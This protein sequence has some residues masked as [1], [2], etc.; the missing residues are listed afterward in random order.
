MVATNPDMYL[1]PSFW[2]LAAI[3][4]GKRKTWLALL[5]N[6]IRKAAILSAFCYADGVVPSEQR[7]LLP[8]TESPVYHLEMQ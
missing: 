4:E 1:H 3:L 7:S 8:S 2:P 6:G 5:I